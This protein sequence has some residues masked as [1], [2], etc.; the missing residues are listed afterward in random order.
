MNDIKE[1][2][3]NTLAG[4]AKKMATNKEYLTF[5]LEQLSA[6]DDIT[7][8]QMMGEYILYYHGKII[9]YLCDNRLLVKPVS[10]ALS[11]LPEAIYEPPYDG[12]KEML[13]VEDVDNKEL[14]T[15]LFQEVYDELLQ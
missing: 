14:L 11:I 7:S 2:Q 5:I 6:L 3:D 9:A 12:A 4:K 8:R 15:K 13:L 10:S 1:K